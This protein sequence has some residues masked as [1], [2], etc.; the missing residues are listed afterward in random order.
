[1][2]GWILPTVPTERDELEEVSSEF[3]TIGLQTLALGRKHPPGET[4]AKRL[5]VTVR[6]PD[7]RMV[8]DGP[9]PGNFH[10]YT[11]PALRAATGAI[12]D[13][14]TGN[15]RTGEVDQ[16]HRPQI[17]AP[18]HQVWAVPGGT[19]ARHVEPAMTALEREVYDYSSEHID[20]DDSPQGRV[21]VLI[22]KLATPEKGQTKELG[23]KKKKS[24]KKQ[25]PIKRPALVFVHDIGQTKEEMLPRM[26]A[27]A[28]RGYIAACIDSRY[29]G[30]R[31][32][33][34]YAF[35]NA[36]IRSWREGGGASGPRPAVYALD[37]V[38]DLVVL[39]D[40][41][42]L[43]PDVDPSRVGVTG[44]G[45]GALQATVLAA[46]DVR[47]S[48]AAPMMGL[49]SVK[50]GLGHDMWQEYIGSS[51][52]T[53]YLDLALPTKHNQH[54][55]LKEVAEQAQKD[56]GAREMNADVADQ[57]WRRLAPGMLELLDAPMALAMIAPR[58]I[59]IVHGELDATCPV[60]GVEEAM[61]TAADWFRALG[62]ENNIHL[63]TF[64]NVMDTTT[65]AMHMEVDDWL[66]RWLIYD[67]E[68]AQASR[69]KL[70]PPAPEEVVKAIAITLQ[71]QEDC[72]EVGNFDEESA[73]RAKIEE[74]ARL[75]N[76][77]GEWIE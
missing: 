1:M 20:G 31:A 53:G 69:A 70:A 73:R 36:L 45:L 10:D 19:Q 5:N 37:T 64:E 60:E 41:L 54:R 50:W 71:K 27:A 13:Y 59:C 26:E 63:S 2:S 17:L 40:L 68:D 57:V 77:S 76:V 23:K 16:A 75:Q 18:N 42:E 6:P 12:C 34:P 15:W 51:R 62:A 44:V 35:K 39:L 67:G 74:L 33:T 52:S 3:R 21:P 47:V 48:C 8:A 72:A 65:P 11:R 32:D 29:H 25:K 55:V 7:V 43:R 38:W 14:Q 46:V 24:D 56:M 4:A 58:P 28:R 66:D 49:L 22:V 9:P 30:G 61:E